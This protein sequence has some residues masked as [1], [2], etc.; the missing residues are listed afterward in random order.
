MDS[1]TAAAIDNARREVEF[2]Y[3]QIVE[4]LPSAKTVSDMKPSDR[5]DDLIGVIQAIRYQQEATSWK[6]RF[7]DL[8]M[9]TLGAEGR[10]IK[11]LEKQIGK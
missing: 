8:L 11:L 1:E 9:K 4:M 2:C 5:G 3:N 6:D 7:I 10:Y